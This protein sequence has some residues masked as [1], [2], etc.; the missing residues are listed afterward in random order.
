MW[1]VNGGRGHSSP[2]DPNLGGEENNSGLWFK[3]TDHPHILTRRRRITK[4]PKSSLF[5]CYSMC[6]LEQ[7]KGR[8]PSITLCISRIIP[9]SSHTQHIR[10]TVVIIIFITL[11]ACLNCPT[12]AC[13]WVPFICTSGEQCWEFFQKLTFTLLHIVGSFFFLSP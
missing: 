3:M 10:H 8:S 12:V 7:G 4:I 1:R 11:F 6:N 9:P 2:I 5:T 13:S